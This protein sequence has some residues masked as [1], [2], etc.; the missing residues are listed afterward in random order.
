MSRSGNTHVGE[1]LHK[2][3]GL[4]AH[5]IPGPKGHEHRH[6]AH[7]EEQDAHDNPVDSLGNSTLR[8]ISL[9]GSDADKLNA[10]EGEHD[11]RQG[12]GKP[13]PAI[14]Q[15]AAMRP[16]IGNIVR[17][18]SCSSKKKIK[19]QDNHHDNSGDFYQGHPK[20]HLAVHAHVDEI[21]QGDDHQAHQ[22]AYPLGQVRQPKV[23][24]NAHCRELCHGHYDVI[25][26]IIP[27]RHK[28]RELAP[29]LVGVVAEGARHRLIHG[30][31]PQ[32]AHNEENHDAS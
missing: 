6:S 4:H 18:G 31:F 11:H 13:P 10:A 8:V 9:P 20:F 12:Q 30:H 21:G 29:V 24:V 22:S 15:E 25:K 27:T 2:G 32:H 14:G 23:H 19:P 17:E 1:N 7:I 26:P 28:A 16:D 5:L 3:A